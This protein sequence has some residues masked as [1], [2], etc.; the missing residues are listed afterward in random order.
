MKQAEREAVE[1]S[2]ESLESG[3]FFGSYW[4]KKKRTLTYPKLELSENTEK[5]S[6]KKCG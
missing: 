6:K 5:E 1:Y 4:N 2:F 3:F